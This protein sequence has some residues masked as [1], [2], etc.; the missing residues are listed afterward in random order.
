MT[1]AS[2]TL[3]P[4]L[5]ASPALHA[6]RQGDGA[7]VLM[8]HCSSGSFQQWRPLVSALQHDAV[9]TVA[10][11]L[12]GHGRSPPW[13]AGE[14]DTLAVD[15]AAA[16]QTLGLEGREVHLV[17]HSYGAAV[18]LQMALM[19]ASRV[20]SM[21]LYEPV[22]FGLLQSDDAMQAPARLE[23]ETVA[24]RVAQ[25]VDADRSHDAARCFT[26]YWAGGDAWG[27]AD[28]AQR[29]RL[30]L[31]M[32]TVRRHF[33]ALLAVRWSPQ[34]LRRL[35]MPVML[36][37]GTRTRE[38]SRA[39]AWHLA[40]ALPRVTTVPLPGAGHLGPMSHAAVVASFFAARLRAGTRTSQPLPL[41][42]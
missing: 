39:L 3:Q 33:N 9:Q 1:A 4:G 23:I 26:N 25:L 22:P 11:D 15:A 19:Q 12:H 29:D 7:A 6:A 21:A 24:L 17:G 31:R 40:A 35:Q 36:M 41:A 13:P 38:P 10:V 42:A 8:L 20:R 2:H 27:H 34:Q 18:A 30:A 28:A 16:W 37:H 32:A 14:R 5:P